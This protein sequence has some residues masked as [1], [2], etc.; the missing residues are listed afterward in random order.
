MRTERRK[1]ETH[2]EAMPENPS[3]T[4]TP[5]TKGAICLSFAAL[6]TFLAGMATGSLDHH[7]AGEETRDMI[8]FT[9]C[10]IGAPVFAF[11]GWMTGLVAVL[12][13]PCGPTWSAITV[14]LIILIFLLLLGYS[15]W[16]GT[17]AFHPNTLLP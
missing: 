13:R 1:P 3:E 12:R 10:R 4:L 6:V 17:A 9:L 2:T 7:R 5:L 16:R 15:L 14:T 8:S 11:S